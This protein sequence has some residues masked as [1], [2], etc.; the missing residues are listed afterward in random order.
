MHVWTTD[1]GV[2]DTLCMCGLS[3]VSVNITMVVGLVISIFSV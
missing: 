2:V 3:A 1:E